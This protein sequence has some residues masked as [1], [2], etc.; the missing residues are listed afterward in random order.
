MNNPP[1]NLADLKKIRDDL[2][3]IKFLKLEQKAIVFVDKYELPYSAFESIL[4]YFKN[5]QKVINMFRL[6][7]YM[8]GKFSYNGIKVH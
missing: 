5:D 1:L 4:Y 8:S 3:G 2:D 7:Y 6:A